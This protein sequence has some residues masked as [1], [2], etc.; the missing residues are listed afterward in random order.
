[1]KPWVFPKK[2]TPF[3][4]E[5]DQIIERVKKLMGW[6]TWKARLWYETANPQFGGV[7][8]CKLV[9]MGRGHKVLAFITIAEEDHRDGEIVR[10]EA[11][12]KGI[13]L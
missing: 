4:L 5:G 8:P 9:F 11:A 3:D 12:A 7:S 13:K 1:M 10:Q 2:K 6:E